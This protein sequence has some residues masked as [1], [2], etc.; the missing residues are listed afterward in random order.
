MRRLPDARVGS[1]DGFDSQADSQLRERR[2]SF[3]DVE[4]GGRQQM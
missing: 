2:R 1:D 3:T 4:V